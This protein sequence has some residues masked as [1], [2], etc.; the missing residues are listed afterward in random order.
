M[1]MLYRSP[2][3]YEEPG[4]LLGIASV[5]GASGIALFL[6]N[7]HLLTGRPEFRAC[8]VGGL[9]FDLANGVEN[10]LGWQWG[11]FQGDTTLYP[12]WIHGSAGVGSTVIRFARALGIERYEEVARGIAEGVMIKY[13][14][15]PSLF[16]GLAGIGEFMLD[17]FRFTGDEAYRNHA[18]DMAE[19]ILWFKLDRPQGATFPG[20]WLTRVSND[21]ATG[22]AG[23][24]LFFERLLRPGPRLFVDLPS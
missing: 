20:R 4:V 23:I 18:F 22:A 17:M 16:E 3:L 19:S 21:Y 7:L 14:F 24:G 8:A 10:G 9:E 1:A 13:A 5:Y 12:Y 15:L 11:R 2:L 6:M